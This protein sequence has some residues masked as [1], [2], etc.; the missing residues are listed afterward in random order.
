MATQ[1]NYKELVLTANYGDRQEEFSDATARLLKK[2]LS[3]KWIFTAIDGKGEAFKEKGFGLLFTP[4]YQEEISNKLAVDVKREQAKI[5]QYNSNELTWLQY[6]HIYHTRHGNAA[7][8]SRIEKRMSQI[9][10]NSLST[11]Y[12]VEI[13]IIGQPQNHATAAYQL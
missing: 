3:W 9:L 8:L 5:E 2:G 6:A 13:S 12:V 1:T 11:K 10:H 4:S 7:E